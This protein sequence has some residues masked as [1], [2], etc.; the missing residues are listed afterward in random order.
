M[1]YTIL[2][3]DEAG[4]SFQ[5]IPT[6]SLVDGDE[7]GVEGPRWA[8]DLPPSNQSGTAIGWL[9]T[10]FGTPNSPYDQ[11]EVASPVLEGANFGE[12]SYQP[13]RVVYP[14]GF[15]TTA[16]GGPHGINFTVRPEGFAAS[17]FGEPRRVVR[18]F[19]KPLGPLSIISPAYYAFGQTLP[20][21]G[22]NFAAKFGTPYGIQLPIMPSDEHFTCQ[23]SSLRATAWGVASW[24]GGSDNDAGAM[25]TVIFGTPKSGSVLQATALEPQS[26][27]GAPKA[28]IIQRASGFRETSWGQPTSCM[29]A[30]A[31]SLYRP[32][33]F[34]TPTARRPS[35]YEARGFFPTRFAQPRASLVNGYRVESSIVGVEFGSPTAFTWQRAQAIPPQTRF[36]TPVVRRTPSC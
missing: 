14:E 24:S 13:D 25:A 6:Y 7:A 12:P 17:N 34:G 29:Y 1:S 21:F 3:G 18:V 15:S 9:T 26:D 36:G 19:A 11:E 35:A 33:R 2:D 5:G 16:F 28:G 30:R 27:F 31:A 23:A 20:A 32:A 10:Q 4:A 8:G 22:A